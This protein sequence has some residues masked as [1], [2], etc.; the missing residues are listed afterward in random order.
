MAP[1]QDFFSRRQNRTLQRRSRTRKYEFQHTWKQ[2]TLPP[3]PANGPKYCL[4][5]SMRLCRLR[6]AAIRFSDNWVL[7]AYGVMPSRNEMRVTRLIRESKN[8]L[9][10]A[11][12]NATT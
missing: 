11:Q 5:I 10:R 8:C 6:S 12:V 1:E 4:L 7:S 9:Q 3:M 2:S